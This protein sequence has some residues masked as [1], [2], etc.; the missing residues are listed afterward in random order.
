MINPV[1]WM[2]YGGGGKKTGAEYLINDL[3]K[4]D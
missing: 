2:G 1:W 4:Q 3:V